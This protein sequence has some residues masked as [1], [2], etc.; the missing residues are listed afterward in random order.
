MASSL[1][2]KLPPAESFQQ[3]SSVD[4]EEGSS[5]ARARQEEPSPEQDAEALLS[6]TLSLGDPQLRRAWLHAQLR[7]L[8]SSRA[9]R[10]LHL[11]LSG[12]A[13]GVTRELQVL[14][15]LACVL[16]DPSARSWVMQLRK[17]AARDGLSALSRVFG[18]GFEEE[19]GHELSYEEPT[20]A[21]HSSLEG[22]PK[23][24]KHAEAMV[25]GVSLGERRRLSLGE[26]KA[27]ARTPQRELLRN[28]LRD[29]HPD[30]VRILLD[31]GRV[32][33][34]DVVRL[35]ARRR[36][37]PAVLWEIAQSARWS[38]RHRVIRALVFNPKTPREV[39]TTRAHLLTRT[40][41][42]EVVETPHVP[43]VVRGVARAL[44]VLRAVLPAYE[45]S[46]EPLE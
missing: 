8:P 26:R 40:D 3:P 42:Q 43:S 21:P 2:P 1:S 30:V 39:A 44:V 4:E 15:S 5:S 41:L 32:I 24:A 31:N 9:A 22:S 13:Q 19:E 29:P 35:A 36:S 18:D 38:Q 11:I 37:E 27:L 46:G 14:R 20:G 16:T 28:L 34:D 6:A 17:Q 25:D 10:A 7:E 45:A 23:E 12:A 33:E